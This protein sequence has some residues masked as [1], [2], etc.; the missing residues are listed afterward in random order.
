MRAAGEPKASRGPKGAAPLDSA[1]PTR[2][3]HD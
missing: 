2:I 1:R 3:T